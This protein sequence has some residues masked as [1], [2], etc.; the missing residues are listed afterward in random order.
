MRICMFVRNPITADPRVKREAEHLGR[1]G[2]EVTV[3]GTPGPGLPRE[4]IWKGVQFRRL[5]AGDRLVSMT[6]SALRLLQRIR[7]GAAPTLGKASGSIEQAQAPVLASDAGPPIPLPRAIKSRLRAFCLFLSWL[8]KGLRLNAHVYHAHDLDTLRIAYLCSRATGAKLV[9]D[10][11]ELFVEWQQNKCGASPGVVKRYEALERRLAPAADL[12]ITVSDGIAR[13]LSRLYSIR[14]PLVVRN[15]APLRPVVRTNKLRE[16]IGTNSERPVLLYQGVFIPGRG[17]EELAVAADRVPFADFVLMGKDSPYRERV[18]EAAT[19]SRHRNVH[20]LPYVPLDELWEFTCGADAGFV[21]TQPVCL[22]YQLSESNKVY[23]YM[24]AGI[25]IVASA[26]ESHQRLQR[27]T[28]ALVL[29]DPLD[30]HDIARGVTVL[31]SDLDRMKCMGRQAR[32]WAEK[33]YNASAEMAK[34]L[35]AYDN[36]DHHA[37]A[38]E[39]SS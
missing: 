14:V 6:R 22:S 35:A 21:L 3:I 39:T 10:S 28:G 4:E 36:L 37:R 34:L 12:V 13:E 1:A 38:G 16:A 11:H 23:E 33:R 9:Y 19:H 8:S 30:P 5:L 2:H 18:R 32:H 20:I 17:L 26:L 31:L 25:P 7:A 24:V 29:V 15:C 27:Q